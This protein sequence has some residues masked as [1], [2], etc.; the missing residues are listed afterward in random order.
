MA[1]SNVSKTSSEELVSKTLLEQLVGRF[2]MFLNATG[3][4]RRF[5]EDF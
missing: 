1:K 4:L 5:W 2:Q 3:R